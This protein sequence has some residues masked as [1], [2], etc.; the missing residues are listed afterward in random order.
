MTATPATTNTV[1]EP[2]ARKP[3]CRSARNP[4]RRCGPLGDKAYKAKKP[5]AID[6]LDFS[7]PGSR[8]RACVREF[9]LNSRQS[10]GSCMGIVHFSDPRGGPAEPVIAMR[11]YS[12][13]SRLAPLVKRVRP[14]RDHLLAVA[15]RL[16]RYPG[17]AARGPAIDDCA[18][19]FRD[20]RPVTCGR[21]LR[22]GQSFCG[23]DGQVVCPRVPSGLHL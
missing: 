1:P 6:F 19:D 18:S 10:P 13:S 22:D 12:D 5:V 14:V 16:A 17:D 21:D 23:R 8:E 15:Q 9:V 4:H 7:T 20:V 11:R 2:R 3:V